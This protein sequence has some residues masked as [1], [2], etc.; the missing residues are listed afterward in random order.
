MKVVTDKQKNFKK[1][2][3][4]SYIAHIFSFS[5][6]LYQAWHILFTNTGTCI[7]LKKEEIHWSEENFHLWQS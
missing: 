4:P 6:Y 7:S 2:E 3:A 5:S 1:E